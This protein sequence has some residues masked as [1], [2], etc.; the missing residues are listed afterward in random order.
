MHFKGYYLNQIIALVFGKSKIIK[1]SKTTNIRLIMVRLG[2]GG[3][4]IK[5]Y[6]YCFILCGA[7]IFKQAIL[8]NFFFFSENVEE[9]GG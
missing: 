9:S 3:S 7:S 4:H 6:F 5:R 1:N 2:Q 8:M